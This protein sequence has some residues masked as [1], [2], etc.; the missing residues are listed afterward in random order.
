MSQF[1]YVSFSRVT[2]C[3]SNINQNDYVSQKV[4]ENLPPDFM[5]TP[6]ETSK[7]RKEVVSQPV[8]TEDISWYSSQKLIAYDR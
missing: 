8:G 7:Y 5:G 2:K 6:S 4:E 1:C 3:Y